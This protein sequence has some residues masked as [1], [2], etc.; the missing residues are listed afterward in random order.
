[1]KFLG[2]QWTTSGVPAAP[3]N[4]STYN[5]AEVTFMYPAVIRRVSVEAWSQSPAGVTVLLQTQVNIGI[6]NLATNSLQ[7]FLNDNGS[8][9]LGA[10]VGMTFDTVQQRTFFDIDSGIL[11]WCKEDGSRVYTF[12]PSVINPPGAPAWV[13]T[14]NVQVHMSIGYE[15][16]SDLQ[17]P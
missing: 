4:Y 11:N 17:G 8:A 15:W 10:S 1:M 12:Q 5:Q 13:G 16:L 9:S 2:L 7:A 6:G 14:E 3:A